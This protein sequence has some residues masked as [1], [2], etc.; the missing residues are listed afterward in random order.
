MYRNIKIR[1]CPK[2]PFLVLAFEPC[3]ERS[4]FVRLTGSSRDVIDS[5]ARVHAEHHLLPGIW[6][7]KCA[8]AAVA[9]FTQALL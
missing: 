8:G 9:F 3:A 1:T 6:M 2:A 4:G 7:F 5:M